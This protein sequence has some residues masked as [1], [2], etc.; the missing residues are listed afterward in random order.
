MSVRVAGLSFA[1]PDQDELISGLDL[2][3]TAGS[4]AVIMAPSGTGKSTLLALLGGLRPPKTG[5]V[6]IAEPKQSLDPLGLVRPEISWVFQAMHL[7]PKRSAA[8]N[9]A[10]ACLARGAQYDDAY[11]YAL[12]CL[13]RFNVAEFAERPVRKLSGGQAQRV[14]L[15]RAAATEALVVLA[16]EPTA[17]LDRRSADQV[18]EVLF[19]GFRNSALI[20]VT[21]DNSF[22][23]QADASYEMRGG[24]LELVSKN[25]R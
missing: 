16:D 4:S 19:T 25:G 7:L 23:L 1:Y 17:N 9:V 13:A 12:E 18:I 24:K 22:A 3:V 10:L 2:A 14:A 21:H 5:S 8:H 11:G 6:E 20:V 15:A